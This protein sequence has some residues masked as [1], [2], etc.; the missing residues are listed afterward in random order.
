MGH[1]IQMLYKE[2]PNAGRHFSGW[3]DLRAVLTAACHKG[4]EDAWF[5]GV[6]VFK[7]RYCAV[8]AKCP[9]NDAGRAMAS[10]DELQK[11][12][13]ALQPEA[14][15][16]IIPSAPNGRVPRLTSRYEGSGRA[17]RLRAPPPRGNTSRCKS[18]NPIATKHRLYIGT[19]SAFISSVGYEPEAIC[20]HGDM[21]TCHTTS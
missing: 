16:I 4:P 12:A 1:D 2:A 20:V 5:F 14:F 18:R 8:K 11:P 13:G 7:T 3:V 6:D 15:G 10:L 21:R 19:L 17:T 9:A